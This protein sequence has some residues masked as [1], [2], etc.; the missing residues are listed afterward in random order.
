M[1]SLRYSYFKTTQTTQ[2]S[3]KSCCGAFASMLRYFDHL[4]FYTRK[5]VNPYTL[6]LIIHISY[7]SL[8]VTQKTQS[9]ERSK[10]SG[11][12][13]HGFTSECNNDSYKEV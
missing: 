6:K 10:I 2:M 5:P 9:N 7:F 8:K 4:L 3:C 1:K 12:G 13:F 11:Y